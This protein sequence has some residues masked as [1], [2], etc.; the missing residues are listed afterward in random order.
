MDIIDIWY[1]SKVD[2]RYYKPRIRDNSVN[3]IINGF[4]DD[5]T[6]AFPKRE[7][8]KEHHVKE[9][10]EGW[11]NEVISND[12]IQRVRNKGTLDI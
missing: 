2:N 4:T 12:G 10:I 7:R 8:L 9:G 11:I 1:D 6:R 3:S 5:Y